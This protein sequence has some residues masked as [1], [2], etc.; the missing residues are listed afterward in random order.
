VPPLPHRVAPASWP[1]VAAALASLLVL[2]ALLSFGPWWPTPGVVLQARLAPEMVAMWLGLLALAARRTSPSPR[3]TWL[4]AA[5]VLVLVLGRYADITAPSLFG[6]PISLYWDVPQ[7]PRF[8]WVTARGEP[9]WASMLAVAAVLA[10]GWALLALI[11]VCLE[12]VLR[13]LAP[14]ALRSVWA[15]VAAF[16]AALLAA[17]HM[18]GV[19]GTGPYATHAVLPTYVQQ[20]RLLW[21]AHWPCPH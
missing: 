10:L 17:A 15:W 19:P 2:N 18:A 21:D 14:R 12:L 3:L 1:R 5:G 16:A 4:L 6:R 13:H 20:L 9:W 7:V 8:L 11:R